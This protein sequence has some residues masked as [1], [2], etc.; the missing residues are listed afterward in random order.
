MKLPL[1]ICFISFNIAYS[2][3]RIIL[4]Q[5]SVLLRALQILT[6][7]IWSSFEDHEIGIV[8]VI[9]LLWVRPRKTGWVAHS[10]LV[11][12]WTVVELVSS[13]PSLP[14]STP[15]PFPHLLF[16][17]CSASCYLCKPHV[18]RDEPRPAPL[19][20]CYIRTILKSILRSSQ[21][22]F[23]L[24]PMSISCVFINLFILWTDLY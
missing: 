17:R 21:M 14:A 19:P 10:S 1:R 4:Y 5:G 23:Y 20:L 13:T 6:Q 18:P 3:I 22:L 15:M 16:A 24:L 8:I 7:L 9:L 2:Y 12:G 11:G